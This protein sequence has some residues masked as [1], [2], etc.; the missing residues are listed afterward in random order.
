MNAGQFGQP[1]A[2][3][4][5]RAAAE[6][7]GRHSYT[8][9]RSSLLQPGDDGGRRSRRREPT[10]Y[11]LMFAAGVAIDARSPARVGF[12]NVCVG[13]PNQGHNRP[14]V[15]SRRAIKHRRGAA[16]LPIQTA[17]LK[18]AHAK[19]AGTARWR[20][21]KLFEHTALRPASTHYTRCKKGP[22]LIDGISSSIQSVESFKSV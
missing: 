15:C 16:V 6:R 13:Y 11:R 8:F 18:I 14:L 1:S 12:M 22:Y 2:T 20:E 19:L 21:G 4:A 9:W 5:V 17:S 10:V 7:S 3:L